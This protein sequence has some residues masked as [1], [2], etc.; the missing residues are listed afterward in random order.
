[1][2][3]LSFKLL[4][5]TLLFACSLAAQ[6][7]S[8]SPGFVRYDHLPIQRV[9]GVGGSLVPAPA[10]FGN[11]ETASFSS[12]GALLATQTE[13]QLIRPD[14][15]VAARIPFQ[16]ATPL[17]NIDRGFSSAVAWL[18]DAR[19][20]LH[21]DGRNLVPLSLAQDIPDG[22]VTSVSI[23]APAIARFLITNSDNTVSAALV[24]LA[25]GNLL[26]SDVLPQVEGPAYQFGPHLIWANR[27]GLQIEENGRT[28]TLPFSLHHFAAEQM[29]D[30][31]IHLFAAG[32]PTHFALC[33][34]GP[35]PALWQIPVPHDSL[36]D[37][38]RT[39]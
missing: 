11:A 25:N 3:H 31:W 29:S 22:L 20:L 12:S 23:A 26:S 13:I 39:K 14:S 17:L 6:I 21:W 9:L 1:M 4:S 10:A 8:P 2:P 15:S 5:C 36:T 28:R 30:G 35:E 34:T 19:I 37:R 38:E 16:G 27:E 18:A 24:S 32:N 33:L 7:S